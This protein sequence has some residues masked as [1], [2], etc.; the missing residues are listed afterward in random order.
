[1]HSGGRQL[2]P[3]ANFFVGDPTSRGGVRLALKDFDGDGHADIVAGSGDGFGSH[4]T[5]YRGA[6]ATPSGTPTVL[7]EFDAF[8]GLNGGVYVG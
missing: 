3:V 5:V 1:M 8:P 2:T 4:V 7:D 6:T